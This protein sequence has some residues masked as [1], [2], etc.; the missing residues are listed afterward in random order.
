MIPFGAQIKVG[1]SSVAIIGFPDL[2]TLELRSNGV[3]TVEIPRPE[4]C[5]AIRIIFGRFWANVKRILTDQCFE[6]EMSQA[7]TSIKETELVLEEDGQRSVVKVVDG[8]VELRPKH[9]GEQVMLRS[10]EKAEVTATD[11]MVSSFDANAERTAWQRPVPDGGAMGDLLLWLAVGV[12]SV[13][14]V[15]FG[16]L[17]LLVVVFLLWR[18]RRA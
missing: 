5:R 17:G 16:L 6:V 14:A 10:G 8:A 11:L 18:A 9:G 1:Y 12:L 15:G 2:S 13:G 4:T 7:A 3:S